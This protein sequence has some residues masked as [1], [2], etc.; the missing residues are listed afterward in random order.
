MMS[1]LP[2][3]SRLRNSFWRQCRPAAATILLA[4][5]A[6]LTAS[7]AAAQML[8]SN[9]TAARLGL[10]RS[11]FAQIRVDPS[12]HKVV[13][14]LLD[15]GQIYALTSAGAVQALDAE[16]GATLWITELGVGHAPAAGIA[17]N[18]RHI[19]LLGAARLYLM[20]RLDGHHLWS[21]SIGGAASA[22]PAL[23]EKYA[24]VTLLS[25]RVEG[26]EL[27]DPSAYVWQYQSAGRTFES[28]TT[29]G[30]VVSW[31]SDSGK[32][33]V[34]EAEA[35]QVLFRVETND[36]IV[37]APA[38]LAPYLYVGSL[39]GY[40]YCYH[41][42]T[43]AEQWR[44]AT[45]FA[46]TSQPAIVGDK[47]FVASEG[48]SLHAVDALTGRPLWVV[49][50]AAQFAALGAQHTYGTDRYGTLVTIDNES[51]NIAG[52]LA[53]SIGNSAIVNDKS[54]RIYLVNDRGL[55]QCLHELGA[56]QPT[57]HREQAQA[58]AAEAVADG[59][60]TE[61]AVADEPPAEQ[62]ED[63]PFAPAPVEDT[64]V[65]EDDNP[66]QF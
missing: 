18:S 45:G 56:E 48:P 30:R 5:M 43:G 3:Q 61:E 16:T 34:G 29:T 53:T 23:S 66:F 52:R 2:S 25:G 17:V 15:H 63:S 39:D 41:E 42:L 12:Q 60:A 40:L 24:Y 6:A 10:K 28:A 51:G 54:D 44:Y 19:A 35:P 32:L 27:D 1:M 8:V 4:L 21:R 58:E 14:W 49:D 64:D 36:E 50:G 55:V 59:A 57:W 26:Y 47:A 20:D 22:A 33:Y 46:I 62:P 13:H 31:P 38:E 65:D 37:A 9:P 11:W 7:T